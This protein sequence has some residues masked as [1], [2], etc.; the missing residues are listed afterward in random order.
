MGPLLRP[1]MANSRPQTAGSCRPS[2]AGSYRTSSSQIGQHGKKNKFAQVKSRYAQSRPASAPASGRNRE[3]KSGTTTAAK[4]IRH[5]GDLFA[6]K[7]H[8]KLTGY[9]LSQ[10]LGEDVKG[11]TTTTNQ[12]VYKKPLMPTIAAPASRKPLV[13][14]EMNARRSQLPTEFPHEA[15]K[16]VRYC[17]ER[18]VSSLRLGDPNVPS[19][20]KSC[21]KVFHAGNNSMAT[22]SA[23]PGIFAD[24]T[25]RHRKLRGI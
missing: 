7:H 20:T 19:V 2:T 11:E 4:I 22:G 5:N 3:A 18:N 16:Y 24:W 25:K 23:N 9:K 1:S 10:Q 21:S 12:K 6:V 8:H 17:H 15:K 13:P 14:Y